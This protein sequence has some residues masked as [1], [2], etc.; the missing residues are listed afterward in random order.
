MRQK[1]LG[2]Y[3]FKKFSESDL[4]EP[5]GISEHNWAEG[6]ATDWGEEMQGKA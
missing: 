1:C 3:Y 4:R 2:Q 5:G 6:P